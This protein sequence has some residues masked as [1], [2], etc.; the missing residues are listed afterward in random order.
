VGEVFVEFAD[1]GAKEYTED[2]CGK[3]FALKDALC[4]REEGKGGQGRAQKERPGSPGK[5][6]GALKGRPGKFQGAQGRAR[7]KARSTRER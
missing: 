4:D 3:A 1:D 2:R 6:Q 5:F 7:R